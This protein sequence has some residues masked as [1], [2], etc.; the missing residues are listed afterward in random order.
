MN[1]ET[2]HIVDSHSESGDDKGSLYDEPYIDDD[3]S[4]FDDKGNLFELFATPG[5]YNSNQEDSPVNTSI[6]NQ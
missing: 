5:D 4:S 3:E 1:E 6:N 2:D